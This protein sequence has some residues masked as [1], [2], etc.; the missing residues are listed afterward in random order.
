MNMDPLL[1]N[2]LLNKLD[3]SNFNGFKLLLDEFNTKKEEQNQIRNLILCSLMNTC[4]STTSDKDHETNPISLKD[5]RVKIKGK[6]TNFKEMYE[7]IRN[8]RYQ[9]QMQNQSVIHQI[10]VVSA[11]SAED[12]VKKSVSMLEE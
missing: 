3:S 1:Y 4:H 8:T 9:S 12:T 10:R 5:S 6:V 11:P 7:M 2:S